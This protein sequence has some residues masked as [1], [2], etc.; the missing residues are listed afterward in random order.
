MLGVWAVGVVWFAAFTLDEDGGLAAPD[1]VS[2]AVT[3]TGGLVVV[4]LA[5][6]PEEV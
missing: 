3:A 5:E 6:A 2:E 4:V 1:P